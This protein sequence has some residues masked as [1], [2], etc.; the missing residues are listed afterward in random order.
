VCLSLKFEIPALLATGGGTIVNMSSTAGVEAVGG[1]AGY[2]SAKH[3]VIG[4]TKTAALEY[5]DRGIRVNAVAPG[6]ILTENLER[7]GEEAQRRA[8]MSMPMRRVGTAAEVAATVLWLCSEDAS[9]ITGAT[10][11]IEGGKLAGMAP[12]AGLGKE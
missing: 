3:G 7:A 2:V 1:L 12:F 11:P 6:P 4:L 5:A 9:Y 8:A 10:I